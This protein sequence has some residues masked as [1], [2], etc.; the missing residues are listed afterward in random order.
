MP[1]FKYQARNNLGK[2]TD[3]TMEVESESVAISALKQKRLEVVSLAAVGG[4]ELIWINLSKKQPNV[5][6]KDVV[7]FSRQFSTMIN[8]GLPILQGRTIV[9]EQSENKDFR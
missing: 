5:K 4:L 2:V 3:G 7:I 8:A 9:A 6:T 1:L